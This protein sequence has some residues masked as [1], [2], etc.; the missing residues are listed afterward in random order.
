MHFLGF[1]A[2]RNTGGGLHA[3]L[4]NELTYRQLPLSSI[5]EILSLVKHFEYVPPQCPIDLFLGSLDEVVDS[6]LVAKHF[7]HLPQ[8]TIHWLK[9]SAHVLPLD[10]DLKHISS[11]ISKNYKKG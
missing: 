8:C 11:C 1:Y 7:E 6:K 3:D 5:I 4:Y 2:L 10:T 9:E